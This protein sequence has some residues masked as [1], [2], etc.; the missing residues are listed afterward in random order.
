M[1][2]PLRE[3]VLIATA[4]VWFF[5]AAPTAVAS[6]KPYLASPQTQGENNS[7]RRD[8]PP[9]AQSSTQSTKSPE[10]TTPAGTEHVPPTTTTSVLDKRES[11]AVLGKK[12]FDPKG[13]SMGRIVNVIVNR[14]GQPRAAIIDFGGF[15]GIGNRKIAVDW[16]ALHFDPNTKGGRITLALTQKQIRAA[17]AYKEGKQIVVLGASGATETI[18][19]SW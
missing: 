5:L 16:K 19:D 8:L 10:S 4:M 7:R 6:N 18:P 1:R 13:D 17:P 11:Q 2:Y 14:A 9:L 15:L 3:A 12:V